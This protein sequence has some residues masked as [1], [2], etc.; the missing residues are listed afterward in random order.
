[1][2]VYPSNEQNV[3]NL[4]LSY[5]IAEFHGG[6]TLLVRIFYWQGLELNFMYFAK[7][8]TELRANFGLINERLVGA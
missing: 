6:P 1:V 3:I 8:A 7:D 2:L 4:H 5:H